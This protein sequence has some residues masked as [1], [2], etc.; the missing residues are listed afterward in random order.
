MYAAYFGFKENPFVITPDPRYL[1]LSPRHQEALA[2]LLYGASEEGGFVQLTG[3]VGAGKTTLI[4]AL[5][6]QPLPQVDFALCLNP[7][8]TVTEFIAAI[9]DELHVSYPRADYTHKL[10][11]DALNQH[12]LRAHSRGRRT[13]L[14][15]DE[16]Q[17]LNRDLLEQVRLLTNLETDRH[18]LMRI[19]LVGQPELQKLLQRPDLRQLAQRITARYHLTAL[20]RRET[21]E[22]IRQRLRIAGGRDD[23]FTRA[24]LSRVYRY[25][26]GIPRL[27]NI[28]CDRALLAAY[29]RD[30]KR[31]D[32]ATLRRAAQEVLQGPAVGK[33]PRPAW[34]SG[35]ALAGVIALGIGVSVYGRWFEGWPAWQPTVAG[36]LQTASQTVTQMAGLE[37]QD[38]DP[39]VAESP[40]PSE[41]ET[42]AAPEVPEA[43]ATAAVKEPAAQELAQFLD[44]VEPAAPPLLEPAELTQRLFAVAD[45]NDAMARLLAAWEQESYIPPSAAPCEYV[46]QLAMRCLNGRGDWNELLRYN[47]P[48]ILRLRNTFGESRQVLLRQL[49]DQT[50]TLDI[51]EQPVQTRLAALEPLWT[52]EYTLLWRLQTTTT[53]IGPGARGEAVLWLRRRLAAA[54]QPAPEP[55]SDYFDGTLLEQVRSYQRSRGL[56][57]DGLVGERTMTLLNNLE[58][59]PNRPFLT[60][61]SVRETP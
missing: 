27:T 22:Y 31:I 44:E 35:A 5:L 55:L 54:G 3:E 21:A 25:T 49:T 28:V 29:S 47:H 14:I 10:L 60:P 46:K 34:P 37:S 8:L 17:H 56:V 13:V 11:V 38:F 20:D 36:W 48:V 32:A 40:P 4:R 42:P 15:I 30:L 23:I 7:R 19:V 53:L 12:L 50:A 6:E 57:A 18:K 39:P 52:G 9:C 43:V 2:H 58:P 59:T 24:A 26:R 61:V 1:Y 51:G 33:A 45:P 41:T 16:A